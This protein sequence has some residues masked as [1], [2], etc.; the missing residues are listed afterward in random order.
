MY[1]NNRGHRNNGNWKRAK[2]DLTSYFDRY[3]YENLFNDQSKYSKKGGNKLRTYRLF[4]KNITFETY[5][6]L[7]DFEKRKAITRLRTSTH[8]LKI[9]TGR[10]NAHNNYIRPEDRT[11]VHCDRTSPEDELHFLIACDMYRDIRN[12]LFSYCVKHNYLFETYTNVQKFIWL[13]TN[14]DME[15]LK[16]LGIYIIKAN[17][18]R[19]D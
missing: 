6:N 2:R 14:E 16:A 17:I 1:I 15:S 10:Y 19:R 5:L 4:K 11:C 3:W 13:M 12:E 9:E 18:L 7:R 8:K